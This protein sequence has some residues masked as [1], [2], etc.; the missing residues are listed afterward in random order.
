VGLDGDLKGEPQEWKVGN[1]GQIPDM[2]GGDLLAGANGELGLLWSGFTEKGQGAWLAHRPSADGEWQTPQ[3]LVD[4]LGG[5]NKLSARLGRDG[6]IWFGLAELQVP[7]SSQ[8][9]QGLGQVSLSGL[10]TSADLAVVG[11]AGIMGPL[12]EN[13]TGTGGISA[14]PAISSNLTRLVLIGITCLFL[15][16]LLG[17]GLAL[18]VLRLRRSRT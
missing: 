1:T 11:A 5:A 9:L 15:L 10:P 2:A 16:A 12:P 4:G 7:T 3:T 14:I 8:E 17:G 18:V 13:S 6:S